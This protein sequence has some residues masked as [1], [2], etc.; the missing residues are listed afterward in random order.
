MTIIRSLVFLMAVNE[1][2][3]MRNNGVLDDITMVKTFTP[4]GMVYGS[5]RHRTLVEYLTFAV[6]AP[7]KPNFYEQHC[8]HPVKPRR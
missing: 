5:Y 3:R 8:R 4:E 6:P 2:L 7:R 1:A